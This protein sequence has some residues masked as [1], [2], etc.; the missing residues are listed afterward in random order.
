[1]EKGRVNWNAIR[2]EYI[3][4]ATSYRQLSQKYGVSKDAVARRAKAENWQSAAEEARDKVRAKSIQKT[5]E[6]SSN[7]AVIAARIQE[8]LLRKIEAEIDAMVD[9]QGSEW[10][11]RSMEM[12]SIE[13]AEGETIA[14]VPRTVTTVRRIRDL[15]AAYKDLTADMPKATGE[16]KNAPV[17]ELLKKLD[18]ECGIG[19]A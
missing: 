8:K 3:G 17:I 5:A 4:G 7:N 12:Q 14:K 16:D 19:E 6:I 11:E 9:G 15:T 18:A 1:M 2:A 13:D 10:R